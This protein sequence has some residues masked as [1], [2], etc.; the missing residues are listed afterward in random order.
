MK[1]RQAWAYA[2]DFNAISASVTPKTQKAAKS[3]LLD[4]MEGYSE[5]TT[6]YK[7][8]PGKGKTTAY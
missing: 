5:N 1:V 6:Q 3:I 4:W 7:Y 2:V 8:D